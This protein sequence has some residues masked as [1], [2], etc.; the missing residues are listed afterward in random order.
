MQ[1]P[2]TQPTEVWQMKPAHGGGR[3]S[4]SIV[5]QISIVTGI[6]QSTDTHTVE[7]DQYRVTQVVPPA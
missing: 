5:A 7:N 3:M 1:I 6:R 4:Q 2:Q